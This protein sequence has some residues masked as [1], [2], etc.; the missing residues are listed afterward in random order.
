MTWKRLGYWFRRRRGLDISMAF[1]SPEAR[2]LYL[3]LEAANTPRD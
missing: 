2:S 1:V 3:I